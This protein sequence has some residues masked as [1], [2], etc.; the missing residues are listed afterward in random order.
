MCAHAL[1]FAH[2][3]MGNPRLSTLLKAIR[4]GF[5]KGCSN[6]NKKLVTKYLNPSPATAKGHMKQPNKGVHSTTPRQIKSAPLPA[7][8]MPPPIAQPAP[9]LIPHLQNIQHYLGPAFNTTHGPNLIVDNESIAN[10][11]AS[12]HL[13][14]KSQASCTTT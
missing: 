13:P 3:S 7:E 12:A 14:T 5:V 9:S 6:L 8:R 10:V 2:Q 4:K 1:E 11:F